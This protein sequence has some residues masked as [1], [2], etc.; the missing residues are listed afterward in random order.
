V[1][2]TTQTLLFALVAGLSP[3]ALLSTLAALGSGRGRLNGTLFALGFLVTQ[4]LVL[5]VAILLGSAATPNRERNHETL[6]AVLELV[7]GVALLAFAAHGR[8]SEVPAERPGESRT[9][10]VLARLRHLRPATAFSV[11]SLL[12][13]GGVKRL[14]ITLFAGATIALTGYLPAAK[15]GLGALYVVIASALVWLPVGVYVVAGSRADGW[16]ASAQERLVANGHRFTVAST[17]VFGVLLIGHAI[18]LLL[19]G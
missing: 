7:L 10:A 17:V 14:T 19:R 18:V 13:V 16:A 4:S 5:L 1:H 2:E 3:L 9:A 12:G 15:A 6:A 8:L 11:G